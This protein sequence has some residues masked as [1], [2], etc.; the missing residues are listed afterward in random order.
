MS[1]LKPSVL[2][3]VLLTLAAAC[4][5]PRPVAPASAP[6]A[7]E[8]TRTVP[9]PPPP[10]PPAPPAAPPRVI[11]PPVP[12]STPLSEEE[13]FRRTSLDQLNA[14]QPLTDVFFDFDEA[15]L[16]ADGCEALDGDA[17]WLLRWKQTGIEIDGYC[18]ER[19]THEYNLALGERRAK[20]ARDYLVDL[21]VDRG[22][23]TTVSFGKE[24]GFCRE[25]N[26]ACWA[27]N[28]RGHFVITSK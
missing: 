27:Q 28:R 18:D 3:V 13:I 14:E 1:H 11:P 25:S 5:A 16:R 22:R 10:A 8:V 12:A 6:A 15:A 2:F 19:G 24:R 21:G 9:Q 4:H 26:E 7:P 20:A 17:H 23:I